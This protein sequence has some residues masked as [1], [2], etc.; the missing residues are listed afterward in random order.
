MLTEAAVEWPGLAAAL[1]E[2]AVGW[3]GLAAALVEAAVRWPGLA[4]V[5]V[6]AA[7]G[8]PGLAAVLTEAA[9]RWP[10]LA[11]SVLAWYHLEHSKLPRPVLPPHTHIYAAP[12]QSS[13]LFFAEQVF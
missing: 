8:W 1:V 5:L 3:L 7:V 6:E 11:V 2:A 10:G 9:V 12:P 4:V 13:V